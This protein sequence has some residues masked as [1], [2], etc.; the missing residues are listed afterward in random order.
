[1]N[2][3]KQ[4]GDYFEGFFVNVSGFLQKWMHRNTIIDSEHYKSLQIET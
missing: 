3:L 1:V 2:V 4:G